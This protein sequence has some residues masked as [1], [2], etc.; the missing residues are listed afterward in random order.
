MDQLIPV[1]RE[2]SVEVQ[3]GSQSKQERLVVVSG[4]GPALLEYG[5]L[6]AIKVD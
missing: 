5:L 4:E 6:R 1:V 3:Y 2:V